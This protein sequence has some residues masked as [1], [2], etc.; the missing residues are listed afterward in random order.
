MEVT[1][2]FDLDD[3]DEYSLDIDAPS[4][5]LIVFSVLVLGIPFVAAEINWVVDSS[6]SLDKVRSFSELNRAVK[7]DVSAEIGSLFTV[8]ADAADNVF[9][10]SI[11][12]TV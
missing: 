8:V 1:W 3:N 2:E 6:D 7:I 5:A 4:V 12:E 9:V 10:C 11:A